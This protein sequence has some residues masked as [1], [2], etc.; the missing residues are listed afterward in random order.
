MC[1][2][3]C[4][5]RKKTAMLFSMHAL[6]CLDKY[7]ISKRYALNTPPHSITQKLKNIG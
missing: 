7:L 6:Q 3:L 1:F 2:L 5:L 4:F